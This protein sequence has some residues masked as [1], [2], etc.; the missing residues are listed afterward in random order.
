MAFSAP[1]PGQMRWRITIEKD[2]CGALDAD[3]YPKSS[4][5]TLC[6]GR[7]AKVEAGYGFDTAGRDE[8][9]HVQQRTVTLRYLAAVDETC[10]VYLHGDGDR[11]RKQAWWQIT[12]LYDPT[13]RRAWLVMTMERTVAQ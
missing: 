10:R 9:R 1:D 12:G 11:A 3:G 13:L 5:Q 8:A 4:V 7:A 2:A 6:E